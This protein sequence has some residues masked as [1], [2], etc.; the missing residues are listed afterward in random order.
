MLI[1]SLSYGNDS[2]ALVQWVHEN[3]PVSDAR[4]RKA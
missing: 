2:I 4:P 3:V 1:L